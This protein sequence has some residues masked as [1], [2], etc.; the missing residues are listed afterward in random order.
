M[1]ANDESL[2][3]ALL[4]GT[5]GCLTFIMLFLKNPSVVTLPER[6]MLQSFAGLDWLHL[7]MCTVLI[8]KSKVVLH[9]SKL[10]YIL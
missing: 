5:R 6:V 7:H 3:S 9:L 2:S 1:F 4:L 8:C 10:Q